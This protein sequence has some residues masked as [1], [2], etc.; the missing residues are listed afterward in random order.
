MEPSA[1]GLLKTEIAYYDEHAEE[2]LLTY[3]NRFVLI[4]G[5]ELI[6]TFESHAEAVGEGVRRY[7]RGPFLVRRTGAKQLVLTAP[8]LSLGLL[9]CQR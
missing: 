9:Q 7:G 3:P 2:L 4:H 6:S 8:A 5:D 1:Q